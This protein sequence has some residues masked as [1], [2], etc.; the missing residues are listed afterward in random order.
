MRWFM[1]P[2]S[3]AA[4]V[5]VF[6]GTLIVPLA[7]GVEAPTPW[8]VSTT[9]EFV[10]VSPAPP[11]PVL[12][13]VS[14]AANPNLAPIDAPDRIEPPSLD[15]PAPGPVIDGA[16]DSPGAPAG[17]TVGVPI[18]G[19]SSL[20]LVLSVP[21][22]PPPR[23]AYRPGGMIREP[24]KLVDVA[25]IY[26]DIARAA[27]VEGLVILEATIDERGVV[28]DARVLRSVPLLDAAALAALKQWRYTPTLLNGVPVRVL[29]TV[30]FRF[31]LGG[32]PAL[33]ADN[34]GRPAPARSRRSAAGSTGAE[35]DREL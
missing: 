26:P 5:A 20:P 27:R 9:P 11:P 8:P 31:S 28:I 35:A 13:A 1:L 30:T 15:D 32:P 19:L 33:V 7:T 24:R 6:L 2:V 14:T 3:A 18:E 25:P 4:H 22:P 16:D 34:S 10:A 12:R 21:T 23:A 17:V 29:M